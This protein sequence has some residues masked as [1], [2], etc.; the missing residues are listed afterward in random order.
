V[1]RHISASET[2]RADDDSKRPSGGGGGGESVKTEVQ[3]ETIGQGPSAVTRTITIETRTTADGRTQTTRTV[4][5]SRGA[6]SKQTD[7]TDEVCKLSYYIPVVF[8][9]SS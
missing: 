9:P 3:T 1:F 7:V 2:K 4:K 5:E 6:S 8:N